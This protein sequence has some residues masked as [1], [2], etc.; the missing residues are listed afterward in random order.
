MATMTRRR[1]V[2][3]RKWLSTVGLLLGVAAAPFGALDWQTWHHAYDEWKVSRRICVGMSLQDV[4]AV[5]PPPTRAAGHAGT[6]YLE[7]ENGTVVVLLDFRERI[8]QVAV[9]RPA[10]PGTPHWLIAGGLTLLAA[11]TGYLWWRDRPPPEG[12]CRVCAYDLR[13]NVSGRCPEC[14]TAVAETPGRGGERSAK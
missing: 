10:G 9:K 2:T 3:T 4:L 7:F 11:Y 1:L 12:H 13:G 8:S 5:M 14:G 6:Q